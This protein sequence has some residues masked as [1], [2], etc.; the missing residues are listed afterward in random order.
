MSIRSRRSEVVCIHL[1]F[2]L[3]LAQYPPFF[4]AALAAATQQGE[5]DK[6]SKETLVLYLACFVSAS[7]YIL[8]M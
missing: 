4:P 1:I 3:S 2:V 5:L 7:D 8:Y 6:W